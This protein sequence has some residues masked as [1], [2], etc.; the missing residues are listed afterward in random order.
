MFAS[1]SVKCSI[2]EHSYTHSCIRALGWL[3]VAFFASLSSA[4]VRIENAAQK[5]TRNAAEFPGASIVERVQAAIRDCGANPC[6]VYIPSGT[7][8]SSPISS[9]KK[10]DSTGARLG[11]AIP[12]NVEIR[13]AGGG[14]TIIKVMRSASE[15]AGTL[16]ANAS[17]SNR[18]IR[19]HDMSIV[20]TDSGSTFDWVSIFICHG[21]D[22]VE[23]DHLTL[24]GNPNKLVNLL[25]ST[26]SSCTR[27]AMVMATMHFRLAASI[28][29]CPSEVKR[30]LCAT[31]SSGGPATT[32]RFRC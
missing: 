1:G 4:Q 22:R 11:I 10:Q 24:E 21:C 2:A 19:V 27:L 9:W 31:T 15:P 6:E 12:S 5:G 26:G 25:D 8:N 23:L 20:W 30:E 29:R 3:L 18:N 28:L 32:A 7:Y 17:E 14:H 16:F 13:G